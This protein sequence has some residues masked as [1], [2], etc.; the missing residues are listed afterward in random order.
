MNVERHTDFKPDR[1][2]WDVVGVQQDVWINWVDKVD[3]TNSNERKNIEKY[4]TYW[5]DTDWGIRDC[6]LDDWE[7]NER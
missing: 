3:K 5:Q 2:I 4:E 1:G 6:D 7:C